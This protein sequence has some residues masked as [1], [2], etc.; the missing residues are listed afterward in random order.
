[1]ASYVLTTAVLICISQF[2]LLT[3]F[4]KLINCLTFYIT[5]VYNPQNCRTHSNTHLDMAAL[6]PGCRISSGCSAYS[7]GCHLESLSFHPEKAEATGYRVAGDWNRAASHTVLCGPGLQRLLM[8]DWL[9]NGS[10]TGS[11][12][13]AASHQ[14]SGL[15]FPG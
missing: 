2:F 7:L 4:D 10:S 13:Q 15:D 14:E 3:V 8:T 5:F 11:Q 9:Y 1:M 6:A 12:L